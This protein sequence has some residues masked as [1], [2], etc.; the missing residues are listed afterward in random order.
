MLE[1]AAVPCRTDRALRATGKMEDVRLIDRMPATPDPDAVFDAFS[2]WVGERGHHA[3][4][5][6]GGGADRGRLRLERHPSAPR[7][8]P[9]RAWSPR[10]RT[11][12]RWPAARRT[13]YTAP[14]KALVSEKFF[15]LIAMFG[16]RERRDDD[17]RRQRQRRTRRSSAA[18]P[19]CW[20]T[21]RCATGPRA[22]IG[23]V[24]MDEFHFYAE[25]DRGWAWQ[26]PLLELPQAQFLLMSATLGDVTR[27]E[28]DLT[29][30]TGRPDRGGRLGRAAGAARATSTG[31]D[32]AA[33]DHRGAAARPAG[34]G[35]RRPLHPGRRGRAGPGADEHQRLH[36]RG[37][38][39]D[40]RA[41]SAAS[42]SPPGSAR[43]CPGW[44]GTASAST[45][46][47]CCR[48][49]GGWSSGSR[50]PGCSRSSAAPTRSASAST[51]RSAPSCS[52]ALTKYDGSR[53]RRLLRPASSTRS[54]AGPGGP[55]FDTVGH[56]VVQAPDHVVENEKALA[57]AGD[58]PKKRR[59]VVRKK[60]PGG[61][62]LL[63]RG[64]PST[65]LVAAEPEP[66][67]SRFRVSHAMLLNVIGRPGDAY[68]GDAAAAA[69][70]TTR[71]APA[72]R[73]H[74]RQAIAIYR[75]CGPAASWSSW[76]EP[77]DEGRYARL[78][79]DLQDDFA[80]NQPLSPFALAAIE[81]LDPRVPDVRAGRAVGDRGDP[82]EPP[83]D[84]VR[85]AEQ[86]AGRG[87][88]ADE[89]RRHRVRGADGAAR[90][91]HLPKPLEETARGALTTST[92]AATRGSPTT[93]CQPKSVVARHVRAGDDLHRVRRVLRA[94]PRRGPG[95]ALPRRRLQ[96]AAAD[97]AGGR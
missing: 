23:Q 46:P 27:F 96:G 93:R 60:A 2:E 69:P 76:S 65:Q 22:D 50:R 84:A 32:A 37:E 45:T 70:T 57:K 90:G 75:A 91:R 31:V 52:P 95:A 54:P 29:R 77:D 14:I 39:R 74:I 7:P 59:K 1:G 56:V 67:Q 6:A 42:G 51:S 38:G 79:V 30:R 55:G 33:R 5:G 66:L 92:A 53:V 13:F 40:R 26:V 19:R 88:R 78:T 18:P 3:L 63:G 47:G 72:Q 68:D 48:S 49:T 58:D 83:P 8:G 86:G 15:D 64:R 35:L 82:G 28:E 87:G 11:S 20:P 61:L 34:A 21:S 62:R 80:L 10:V 73:R 36:P 97:R 4:P 25:P 41:R 44:S 16:S 17:R 71:T 94:R 9:E 89:G 43:R 85:P 81:L 24:V 12:P